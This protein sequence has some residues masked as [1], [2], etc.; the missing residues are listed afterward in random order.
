MIPPLQMPG[1]SPAAKAGIERALGE[2]DFLRPHQ[3]GL[4]EEN[5]RLTMEVARLAQEL[6]DLHESARIW[7]WLYEKQLDRAN[8]AIAELRAINACHQDPAA[9]G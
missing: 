8:R 7:I 2:P 4:G 5:A 9:Y 3:E 6:E 1:I